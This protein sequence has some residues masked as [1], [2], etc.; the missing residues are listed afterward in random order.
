MGEGMSACCYMIVHV[1]S[2]NMEYMEPYL[3]KKIILE[4]HVGEKWIV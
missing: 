1:K 3:K 2:K 4:G